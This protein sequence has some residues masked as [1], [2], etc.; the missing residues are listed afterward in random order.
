MDVL[1]SL[2]TLTAYIYSIVLMFTDNTHM[3]YFETCAMLL[4]V[5][6]IGKYIEGIAKKKT[7]SSL[8]ELMSLKENVA[9]VLIEDKILQTNIQVTASQP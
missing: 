4:T 6:L 7:S 5:I 8:K 1:V 3:L 9:K 2:G